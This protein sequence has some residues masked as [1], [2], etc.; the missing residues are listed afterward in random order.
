MGL[1]RIVYLSEAAKPMSQSRLQALVDG[2]SL[3]NLAHGVTGLLLH[4]GGNFMQVIEG[5]EM[6]ISTLFA[7][8]SR[9]TRH[10]NIRTLLH[11]AADCRLFPEWGMH[12]ATTMELKPIDS[13]AIDKTVMR[14]RL[15]PDSASVEKDA[16][17]LLQEFRRQLMPAA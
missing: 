8:I 16:M 1:S 11:R 15:S 7:R 3:K 13:D 4:S 12:L 9:D 6:I 17:K 10:K 14:L 5:D 2:C